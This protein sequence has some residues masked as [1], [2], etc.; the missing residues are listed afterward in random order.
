MADGQRIRLCRLSIF[1]HVSDGADTA[2][3]LQANENLHMNL[4][5]RS[6]DTSR[7]LK[8]S[9]LDC[10]FLLKDRLYCCFP[11]YPDDGMRGGISKI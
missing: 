5:V 7:P 3:L 8:E 9:E 4:R 2:Q 11:K 6:S 1:N 10:K